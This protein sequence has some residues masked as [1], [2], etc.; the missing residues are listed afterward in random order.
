[1]S[2]AGSQTQSR[3]LSPLPKPA[4]PNYPSEY[5]SPLLEQLLV[6]MCEA[7]SLLPPSP[8]RAFVLL[9]TSLLLMELRRTIL[10]CRHKHK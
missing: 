4:A 1:M 3:H 6:P 10:G 9:T 2:T 8:Q 5:I 7:G